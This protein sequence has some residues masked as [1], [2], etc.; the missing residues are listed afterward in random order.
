VAAGALKYAARAID[1]PM[2]RRRK[3]FCRD[4]SIGQDRRTQPTHVSH[5]WPS[6]GL[7]VHRSCLGTL[8]STSAGVLVP[9]EKAGGG[10]QVGEFQIV[11]TGTGQPRAPPPDGPV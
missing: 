11:Y 4:G 3:L 6:V 7:S 10:S 2:S 1:S 8:S 9:N 5:V